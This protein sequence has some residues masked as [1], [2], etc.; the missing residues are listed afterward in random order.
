MP[1]FLN[2]YQFIPTTGKINNRNTPVTAYKELASTH[3]RHDYWEKDSFSGRMVCEIELLTPTVIGNHQSTGTE[4][5]AGT[6][7]PYQDGQAIPANSLRGMVSSVAEA[8]SQSALRVL[9]QS[10]YSV[11]KEVGTG[12]SAIGQLKKVKQPNGEESYLLRPLCLPTIDLRRSR[13]IPEQW[14]RLFGEN[15]NIFNWLSAYIDGYRHDDKRVFKQ[16][17]SFL[18]SQKPNCYHAKRH[19]FYYAKLPKQEQ[20]LADAITDIPQLNI[21][22][23]KFLLGQ[24]LRFNE[25]AAIISQQHYDQLPEP[26]KA[27]YTRGII[28]ALGIEGREA[29]IPHTKKHEK[30]IPIPPANSYGDKELPIPQKVIDD[31]AAIAQQCAKDSKNAKSQTPFLPQGYRTNKNDDDYWQP[32]PGEL[33]YF[34]ID[35]SGQV[36]EISYSAIWRKK[37]NGDS[38]KAFGNISPNLL[39]WGN[40]FRKPE[41]TG[42][43]L[44][45]AEALFG[46][47]AE[48]KTDTT[49]KS[50]NLA[51][52]VRF[53]DAVS[54]IQI[55]LMP[56]TL[57]KILAGPKPPAPC[58]YFK[59]PN[60]GGY[61]AKKDLDL[62]R[63]QPNGRKIYLHHAQDTAIQNSWVSQYPLENLK[64]KLSC[65]PM[66]ADSRLYFHI[67]FNNLSWDELSLLCKAINPDEHFC[68]RLGL[69]KPLGLGSVKLTICGLFFIDRP[70][71]YANLTS[72]RYTSVYQNPQ[73][74]EQ[75][76]LNT[77]Y[78]LEKQTLENSI[79]ISKP[80]S[81]TFIDSQALQALCSVGD[82]NRQ[83]LPVAYPYANG[84]ALQGEQEGFKWFGNNT[85]Q[86]L[87]AM[88]QNDLPTLNTN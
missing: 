46:V 55:D 73:W 85:H 32:A 40:E 66:P 59:N 61:I 28:H 54:L 63:H 38:Y 16:R 22:N 56:E 41:Q 45:P 7:T 9:N 60:G 31:F 74:P 6:V 87:H 43:G 33:V 67:D 76:A 83:T 4:T 84:Q 27:Q 12:L 68:H 15:N 2:P 14:Q 25:P 86:T 62:S 47:V 24:K 58:M 34:D 80:F 70:Q 5:E 57:L 20:S 8:L 44:T 52:R 37:I 51:A 50:Y 69:G 36:T 18:D 39:P 17:N 42:V 81:T 23:G 71:R 82:R 65:Q 13:H 75:E 53:S 3:I 72:P 19:E 88:G 29:E 35:A 30:F 26:E 10:A 1:E 49:L 48:A 11:R 64:Q 78:R 79:S 21:K 77:F